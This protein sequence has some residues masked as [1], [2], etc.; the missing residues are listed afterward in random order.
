MKHSQG[1]SERGR[2]LAVYHKKYA[3]LTTKHPLGKNVILPKGRH[4]AGKMAQEPGLHMLHRHTCRQ[5]TYTHK[6]KKNHFKAMKSADTNNSLK[7]GS[8]V[9]RSA[10]LWVGC[11]TGTVTTE[12]RH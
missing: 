5:N 10:E 3:T 7:G 9:I 4:G 2:I 6:K 1:L 8:N 12:E 11:S